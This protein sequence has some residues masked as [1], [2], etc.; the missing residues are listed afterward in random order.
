MPIGLYD[1]IKFTPEAKLKWVEWIDEGIQPE[2]NDFK[3][4]VTFN[5]ADIPL[6]M[7]V[8]D[9]SETLLIES[10]AVLFLLKDENNTLSVSKETDLDDEDGYYYQYD[11][12]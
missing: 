6:V 10:C 3:I 8:R 9:H 4:T 1:R 5:N 12:N 7:A 2:W 11:Y